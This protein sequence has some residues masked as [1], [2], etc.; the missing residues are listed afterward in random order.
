LTSGFVVGG[1]VPRRVLIRAVGPTLASFG[2]SQVLLDPQFSVFNGSA[3][4]GSNDDWGGSASLAAL[5]AAIGAFSLPSNSQDAAG[6]FTLQPGS[7][8]VQVSSWISGGS[9]AV[10]LEIYFVD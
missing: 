8:T 5:F 7:Y 9:G 2:V 3:V 6:V 10:L 4:V 1:N